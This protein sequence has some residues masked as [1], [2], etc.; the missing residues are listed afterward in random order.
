MLRMET[1]FPF[2]SNDGSFLGFFCGFGFAGKTSF[3]NVVSIPTQRRHAPIHCMYDCLCG[4]PVCPLDPPDKEDEDTI[5]AFEYWVTDKPV[6][7]TEAQA[8]E[9]E[10]QMLESVLEEALKNGTIVM[11]DVDKSADEVSAKI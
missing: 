11:A 5:L 9:A 2:L 3:V 4:S 8:A 6:R 10:Q 1:R 7:L